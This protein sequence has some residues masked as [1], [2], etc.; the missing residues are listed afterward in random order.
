MDINA[1][2]RALANRITAVIPAPLT[3]VWYVPDMVTEPMCWTKPGSIEYDRAY[4]PHGMEQLNLEVFLVVSRADDQASQ[5]NLDAYIHGTGA[6][7]IKAA[8]ESGREQ[9]GG[10]AYLGV[11]DDVW[12]SKCDSYQ[13]YIL[14][15]ARF[16]GATFTLTVIGKG[17][18]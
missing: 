16:L 13:Y 2:R 14:G 8:I 12:V 9:Y 4:G 1:V 10:T 11:F 5:V 3:S 18:V 17:T 6:S 7:S 15:D